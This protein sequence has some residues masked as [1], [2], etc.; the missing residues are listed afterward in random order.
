MWRHYVA[1]DP[2]GSDVEA[3]REIARF[4]FLSEDACQPVID[5]G[6][7]EELFELLGQPVGPPRSLDDDGCRVG[8]DP[9]AVAR[10]K[11]GSVGVREVR[12]WR[13]RQDRLKRRPEIN[14]AV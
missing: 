12:R 5:A 3:G 11:V 1:H 8:D 9:A 7:T 13:G 2:A 14:R 4:L 10:L 6:E